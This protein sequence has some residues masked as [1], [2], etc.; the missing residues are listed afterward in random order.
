MRT[1]FGILIASMLLATA[2]ADDID[3]KTP[4]SVQSINT[5]ED[6]KSDDVQK[7]SEGGMNNPDDVLPE[8]GEC[9]DGVVNIGEACDD[10][11]QNGEYDACA[12]DCQGEGPRCGDGIVDAEEACDG[13]TDLTCE[14]VTKGLGQV[15]CTAFCMLD[16]TSCA[17]P[18]PI[19]VISEIMSNPK[20]Q[21]DNDGEYFE[22]YNASNRMVDLGGCVVESGKSTGVESFTIA[23]NT[24]VLQGAY[25]VFAR[26][27][28]FAGQADY[29]Y[30]GAIN[31]NNTSDYLEIRCGGEVIDHVAYDQ[32]NTFPA[33]DGVSLNLNPS[34]MSASVNDHGMSWCVSSSSFGLGDAGTPG[35]PN[36]F[37][38]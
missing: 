24:I 34:M 14:D 1:Q 23:P 15:R 29:T 2:C 10:G 37:C 7:E 9:G 18:A 33:T 16:T 38:F 32:A 6:S 12:A 19:L 4:V 21:L 30:N 26:S 27:H 36:D 28:M 31:L 13:S 20:A 25:F 3:K 5:I 35:A 17:L 22:I 8:L 11:E